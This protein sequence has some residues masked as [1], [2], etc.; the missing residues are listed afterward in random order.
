MFKAIMYS[1]FEV[2]VD[3]VIERETMREIHEVADERNLCIDRVVPAEGTP[4]W[5]AMRRAQGRRY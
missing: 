3:I 4:E 1:S 2:D 5:H